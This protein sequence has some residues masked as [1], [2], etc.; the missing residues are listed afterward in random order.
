MTCL[1]SGHGQ[2]FKAFELTQYSHAISALSGLSKLFNKFRNFR[3][4]F[5]IEHLGSVVG[6]TVLSIAS[7]PRALSVRVFTLDIILGKFS[8]AVGQACWP[9]TLPY[10]VFYGFTLFQNQKPLTFDLIIVT[11]LQKCYSYNRCSVRV[12]TFVTNVTLNIAKNKTKTFSQKKHYMALVMYTYYSHLKL[13]KLRKADT[14]HLKL[15]EI[16]Q[17]RGSRFK[18]QGD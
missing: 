3:E 13:Y 10:S 18:L 17:V 2:F 7:L 4:R 6:G 12:V 11:S 5:T 14:V 15:L 8:L 9:T 16:I 1:F